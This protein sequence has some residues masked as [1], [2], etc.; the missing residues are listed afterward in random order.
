MVARPLRAICLTASAWSRTFL[1]QNGMDD[2]NRQRALD[3]IW[4]RRRAAQLLGQAARAWQA[5][6]D[7][8]DQPAGQG[9]PS[10]IERRRRPGAP[11][12]KA[13]Y[14]R[15]I[16]SNARGLRPGG[17]PGNRW[18]GPD[19][20]TER[21]PSFPAPADLGTDEARALAGPGILL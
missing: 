10:P 15:G 1:W 11:N 16:G 9:R 12:S 2:E 19:R 4:R 3:A 18:R 20:Q 17:A 7:V 5:P 13:R 6:I 21:P 14:V 8:W